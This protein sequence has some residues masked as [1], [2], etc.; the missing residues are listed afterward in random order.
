MSTHTRHSHSNL[1]SVIHKTF[2]FRRLDSLKCYCA[3]MKT[4][5]VLIV[6]FLNLQAQAQ[7]DQL[8]RGRILDENGQGFPYVIVKATNKGSQTDADGYFTLSLKT[9]E[10]ILKVSAIGYLEKKI[11]VNIPYQGELSVSLTP[12]ENELET[13]VITATRTS[14]RLDDIPLPVDVIQSEEI[15]TIGSLRLNEVLIEQTGLQ[16]IS[17]HGNGIQMQGLN[18]EYILFLI[19]GEP[20]IG[21]TAGTLELSR[22]AVDNIERVEIIKGPSSSLYGSEAMAGVINIIT[23]NPNDGLSSSLRGRYRSFGTSDVSGNIGYSRKKLTASLFVNRLGTDGY[24]LTPETVS[25]TAPPFEAY[26]I[27]P[28]FAYQFSDA[29]K[30]SVNGRFYHESQENDVDIILDGDN[31]RMDDEGIRKDWSVMPTLEVNMNGGH[32]LQ[33][34]SYT[35]G[36]RTES[37]LLFQAD[38]AIYNESF[39]DQLFNRSEVQHDWYINDKNITTFGVGHTIESVE[40][41]RY[42]DVNAFQATYGFIQHQ[43][44]PGEKFNVIVGG[45]YDTHSEYASR[46]SPKLAAG[47]SVN[48]WLKVQASFGGGYKAPDFRQLLLNFTNPIAGY[49]VVGSSIVRERFAEFQNQG[50]IDAILID[51][52]NIETIEAET[53]I[54]YNVGLDLFPFKKFNGQINFFRN[55]INNL[56]DTSPIARKTNGQSVFSYFNFDEVITQGIEVSG[57]Y[58]I[59]D[60][61]D[62][63]LGYQYLDSRNVEDVERIENGEVF[64][65][66]PST[67]ATELVSTSDYGGLPGRSRHSGNAKIFYTNFMHQFDV[68]LRAIY[69]GRWALGDSNGNGVIDANN[70]F[71]DGYLLLNIAIN[72][73]MF[74]WLTIEAGANNLTDSTNE[75]EPALPGRIWYGGLIIN[76]NDSSDSFL[77]SK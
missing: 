52:S 74:S 14:R 2:F 10:H 21:R 59:T 15:Q 13:V 7:D 36:Y 4:L 75:F 41:T 42:D 69:R 76:F 35:T 17:D 60:G 19:D 28:K 12:K 37:S 1:I 57:N 50:L 32:R 62:V 38:G 25:M 53:S 70:E 9:G 29:I 43:W 73:K 56:I 3:I 20:I 11:P 58:E 71:S 8:L 31:V 33:L 44:I 54:N 18:S 27:N 6:S 55:E 65:R 67:N 39:F 23:K 30:L 22:L 63:S 68:A 49:S 48:P 77:N 24:D 51:P 47:Y 26:T 16:I 40:A 66:N 5:L 34:R 72:K 45:R 61:L 46:F 64:R